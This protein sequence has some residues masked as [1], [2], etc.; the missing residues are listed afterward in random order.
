MNLGNWFNSSNGES[1]RLSEDRL[2]AGLLRELAGEVVV[3]ATMLQRSEPVYSQVKAPLRVNHRLGSLE[4]VTSSDTQVVGGLS[5][6]PYMTGAVNAFVLQ[7]GLEAE[8]DHVACIAEI[9]RVLG[10][11]GRAIVFTLEPWGGVGI[12]HLLGKLPRTAVIDPFVI[13]CTRLFTAGFLKRAFAREGLSCER[14]RRVY[15]T[16]AT[17][18][19]TEL[20]KESRGS[21]LLGKEARPPLEDDLGLVGVTSRTSTGS[22][23]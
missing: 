22:E 12:R 8:H 23:A 18:T 3:C 19:L 16:R 9:S 20:R 5:A 21:D 1:L 4:G 13:D 17:A 6:M 10:E 14:Q 2:L 15:G 11:G 7:H